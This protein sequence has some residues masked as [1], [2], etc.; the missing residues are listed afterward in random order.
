MIAESHDLKNLR[1]TTSKA[2]IVVLWLHVPICLC[3]GLMLSLI[4]I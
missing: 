1:E 3:I 4:H 2:L